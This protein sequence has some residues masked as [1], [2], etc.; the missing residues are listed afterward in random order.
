MIGFVFQFHHFIPEF[1]VI[2]NVIMPNLI[3][4]KNPTIQWQRTT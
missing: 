4:E 2:D 1:N 3:A